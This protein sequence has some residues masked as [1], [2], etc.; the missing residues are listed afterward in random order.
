MRWVTGKRT[1]AVFLAALVALAPACTRTES[2]APTTTRAPA[3]STPSD[4][5]PGGGPV[6]TDPSAPT[7]VPAT[8]PD[9]GRPIVELPGLLDPS[10]APIAP[11]PAVRTGV[12][13]NGLTYYV[14]DN[15]LPGAHVALRLVIGAGSADELGPETGV[16]HF[17]EHML[18]NGT[19]S[20]P[21]NELID[22]LRGFGAEFGADVNA[23]TSYDE[24]VYELS[25]PN[26]SASVATALDVLDQWLVHATLDPDEVVAERGVVLDEWRRSTQTVEGRLFDL[27]EAHYLAGSRYEGR[28]A[29]GT[30]T[31]ISAMNAD[32]L[33]AYYDA[34]YR[35]DN[36]AVI[37]VGEIEP[38]AV[39]EQIEDGFGDVAARTPEA[40]ARRTGAIGEF[41]EPGFVLHSDPDQTTVDVEV[42]LPLPAFDG[43]GTAADRVGL[44]D[45]VAFDVLVR[46]LDRDAARGDAPFDDVTH[47]SN[48]FV[49]GLDA[50]ALYAFTDRERIDETLTA[51]LDEYERAY[52]FGFDPAE[53]A[54]SVE[55][56]RAGFNT[57]LAGAD[58][59]RDVEQ[60]DALVAMFLDG[61]VLGDATEQARRM[62]DEAA[63][64]TPEAVAERFNARYTNTTPQVIVSTPAAQAADMPSADAVYAAIAA[65]PERELAPREA[66]GELPAELVARPDPIAPSNER[67]LSSAGWD[68]FDPTEYAYPNGV[69]V[70]LVPN[71]IV[72]G[73]LYLQAISPGGTAMLAGDDL[74]D[75]MFA[76]E[77]VTASGAGAFA[78]P[79]LRDALSRFDVELAPD[80]QPYT[81][82][83][84]G[85]AAS[86]D[87]ESLLQLMYLYMTA[88][89]VDS[90]VLE[91]TVRRYQPTIDDP[92]TDPA[93]A[94]GAALNRARYGDSPHYAVLP[95][96]EQFA[97][98][99]ADGIERVWR[100]RFGDA[101]DWVFVLS[102]DFDPAEMR[103]LSDTYLATLPGTRGPE[104]PPNITPPP[105]GGVVVETVTA[106]A[107]QT[108]TVDL[109][110]T[111][112]AERLHP[113]DD[114]VAE[115]AGAVLAGRLERV[116]REQYGDSYSPGVFAWIDEDPEPVVVVYATATGAPDR[117]TAIAD[118][119]RAEFASI[120]GGNVSQ[121]EFDAAKAPV[122]ERHQ[123]VDNGQFLTHVLRAETHTG[124]SVDDYVYDDATAVT[125]TQVLDFLAVHLPGDRYVQATVTPR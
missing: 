30:D 31:S 58:D 113:A 42:T 34:W 88:P 100:D 89:R 98:L 21:K 36:A 9:T 15:P 57:M 65:T 102:G 25:V 125:L 123:Y 68:L 67:S 103:G 5:T 23:Y 54:V 97:T 45:Y 35:P 18:F 77:I 119:I 19:E 60:A 117:I 44:L 46:R 114:T 118:T 49:D 104:Q 66:L 10:D 37:V 108:A 28:S 64:I 29:I 38:D 90:V 69:K 85:R 27:A 55:S 32:V 11:D 33:R 43:H 99:D 12:L 24:T 48:S 93:T 111:T 59:V 110:F 105:P 95:T 116:V 51:L 70:V 109:L 7:S 63:A 76:P 92:S 61:V 83:W 17:L 56:L 53:I 87:A 52:R 106:G 3:G 47:G 20:Y 1:L 84:S 124:Y 86:A 91:Q 96:P 122:V 50:P 121:A 107:G 6:A 62:L 79:E 13:T 75:A 82:G 81:E 41:T 78:P 74:V 101:S 26:D 80:L 73:E 14:R 22:V 40:P 39:V 94:G 2:S 4:T 71:D 8:D 112:P 115:I 72:V 120:A 16:A